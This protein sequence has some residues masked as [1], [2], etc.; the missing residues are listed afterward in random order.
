MMIKKV[1]LCIILFLIFPFQVLAKENVVS[2]YFFH[3]DTCSHCIE[4]DK[5][6]KEL[7][8]RYA[9]V[10]IYR[11]EIQD[12]EARELLSHVRD[13]YGITS[14]GVPT[15]VIGD[16]IYV[17][18]GDK[19]VSKFIYTI[20]Y[21]SHYSYQNKVGEFIKDGYVH[22]EENTSIIDLNQYIKDNSIEVFDMSLHSFEL[23]T[24]SLLL[25]FSFLFSWQ[26]L[27]QLLI[28]FLFMYLLRK[29][30][31]KQFLFFL[32]FIIGS[33]LVFLLEGRFQLFSLFQSYYLFYTIDIS[34][35]YFNF[36]GTILLFYF[37]V[38][39]LYLFI[40]QKKSKER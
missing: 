2:I 12:E 8:K 40:F 20:E 24:S 13:I 11:Y 6:L 18:F 30:L 22:E 3:S 32:L 15:T 4:E 36:F 21:Y 23:S 27:I 17:G 39:L 16:T 26:V 31:K 9:N 35:G 14:K 34:I 25:A 5:F 38:F 28:L 37:I 29:S 1:L 7:E 10:K 19:A 33:L